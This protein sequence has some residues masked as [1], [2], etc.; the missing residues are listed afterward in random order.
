MVLLEDWNLK[1]KG[2]TNWDLGTIK[3]KK[4]NKNK[5]PQNRRLHFLLTIVNVKTKNRKICNANVT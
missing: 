4:K 1:S 2:D 3:L 5:K